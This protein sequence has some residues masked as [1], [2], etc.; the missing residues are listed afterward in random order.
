MIKVSWD[1]IVK[2]ILKVNGRV[3]KIIETIEI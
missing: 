2:N 3:Q 1:A